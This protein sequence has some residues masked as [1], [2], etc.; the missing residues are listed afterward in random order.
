MAR[1]PERLSVQ[2]ANPDD[3]IFETI[4]L[5]QERLL[6]RFVVEWAKL[7]NTLDDLIW[8]FF[9]LPIAYGR[10]VTSRMDA[11]GKI[12]MLRPLND[13]S[14][15]LSSPD[16]AVHSYIKECLEQIKFL[17]EER[18]LAVHGTWGRRRRTI[19]SFVPIAFSLRI[20]DKPTTVVSEDFDERRIRRMIDDT[21][22]LK[23]M[24][25]RVFDAASAAHCRSR[26]LLHLTETA[27]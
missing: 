20:K 12:T 26:E 9:D 23:W 10:I 19:G 13:M 6:G 8:H 24:A 2:P 4:S 3:P 7:E 21:L 27:T 11:T 15:S 25:I 18:N 16:Y 5:S 17:R 1:R 14:F 22:R